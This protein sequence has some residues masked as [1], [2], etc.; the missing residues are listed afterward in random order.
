MG[1]K[2]G[3]GLILGTDPILG[4]GELVCR[5][6]PT[7]VWH[8][9]SWLCYPVHRAPQGSAMMTVL[10]ALASKAM[11][12]NSA[13]TSCH[14]ISG[15]TGNSEGRMTQLCRPEVGHRCD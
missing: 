2:N 10:I 3:M 4:G 14:Q 1:Q 11:A 7:W 9:R 5:S 13:T 12:I 8:A 15:P 6:V